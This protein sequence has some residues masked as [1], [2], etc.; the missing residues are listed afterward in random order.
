MRAAQLILFGIVTGSFLVLATLGFALIR[1]VEGFLNVAHAELISVSAFA[2]WFLNA[3]MGWPFLAAALTAVAL[4]SVLGL[5]LARMFYDPL[6]DRGPAVLLITSVG[7]AFLIH[8]LLAA[9][10]GTGVRVYDLAG[11]T[12]I[13]LGALVTTSYHIWLV[14]AAIATSLGLALFLSK[15]RTGMA[16]RAVA[17]NRP[18]AASRG[19]STVNT[20]RATWLLAS[21]LAGLAGVAL[22]VIATLTTDIAFGQILTILAVAILAGLGSLYAVVAAGYLVGVTMDLSVLILPAGYREMVAFALVILILM[23]RPSGLS[24]SGA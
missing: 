7:V 22:G 24:G 19:I 23:V 17:I 11:P 20:S 10:I 9:A 21:G 13:R 3:E 8:G 1:R 18:L 4:T 12:T 5:G 15:T 14:V 2:T 16:I 6:S